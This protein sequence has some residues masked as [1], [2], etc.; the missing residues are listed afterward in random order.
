MTGFL[1]L[2]MGFST[3]AMDRT[4]ANGKHTVTLRTTEIPEQM[5]LQFP[6]AQRVTFTSIGTLEILENNGSTWRYRPMLS[7]DVNG[8]RKYLVPSFRIVGKDRVALSV[9]KADKSAPVLIDGQG[10]TS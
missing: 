4:D 1:T 5:E 6:D 10:P 2:S 9:S 8:K 3:F 7:Q